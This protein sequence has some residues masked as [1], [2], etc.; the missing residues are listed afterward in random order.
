MLTLVLEKLGAYKRTN[1]SEPRQPIKD[2]HRQPSAADR[3]SNIPAMVNGIQHLL[4]N[5]SQ[6]LNYDKLFLLKETRAITGAASHARPEQPITPQLNPTPHRCVG[7]EKR[8]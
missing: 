1:L 7:F 6:Y 2:F 3:H 4:E 8:Y 5:P